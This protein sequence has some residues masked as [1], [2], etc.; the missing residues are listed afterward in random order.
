MKL[1]VCSRAQMGRGGEVT[2]SW[3]SHRLGQTGNED[4]VV[5]IAYAVQ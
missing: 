4:L 1:K 2:M 3:S 5:I